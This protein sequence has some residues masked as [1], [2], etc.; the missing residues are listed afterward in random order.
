M[1][2]QV[3]PTGTAPVVDRRPVPRGVLPK[4]VQTWL[5]VALAVGMLG[6][7]FLT[8]HAQKGAT[9]PNWKTLAR[10]ARDARLTLVIYMGVSSAERIQQELLAGLP[11]DTPVAIVQRASLPDQRHA[12]T[13]LGELAATIRGEALA[14]PSVIVVGDVVGAA[15]LPTLIA[16]ARP[17]SGGCDRG[18]V[19]PAGAGQGG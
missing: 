11:A 1:A 5:M 19:V 8:G 6:V 4:G 17:T 15:D 3:E 10:T 2:D 9:P 12:V 13:R 14:S 18:T 16:A 7:I